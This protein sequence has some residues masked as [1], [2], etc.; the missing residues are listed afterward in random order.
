MRTFTSDLILIKYPYSPVFILFLM[1][2]YPE[3]SGLLLLLNVHEFGYVTLHKLSWLT[4]LLIFSPPQ[5][6]F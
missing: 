6:L 2:R 1:R 4:L 3:P 5:L